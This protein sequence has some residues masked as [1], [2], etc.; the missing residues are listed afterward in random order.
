MCVSTTSCPTF[1]E[2][3]H[4]REAHG[5]TE[6][7]HAMSTSGPCSAVIWKR[8]KQRANP[9]PLPSVLKQY[10]L[11]QLCVLLQRKATPTLSCYVQLDQDVH[12]GLYNIENVDG[13][14]SW[15][16]LPDRREAPAGSLVASAQLLP[17]WLL[18]RQQPGECAFKHPP[19]SPTRTGEAKASRAPRRPGRSLP[20]G[21]GSLARHTGV[22]EG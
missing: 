7:V 9:A 11:P 13:G 2:Q 5:T 4:P 15:Q 16:G 20:P 21:A 14:V 10:L 22:P 1:P 8:P 12:T 3:D 17:S 6:R 19:R 18:T